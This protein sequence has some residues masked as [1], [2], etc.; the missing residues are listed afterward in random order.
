MG[1]IGPSELE[2][3]ISDDYAPEF[4]GDVNPTL[5][6][7]SS[8]ADVERTLASLAPPP[9]PYISSVSRPSLTTTYM[10][11]QTS[12]FMQPQPTSGHS[13]RDSVVTIANRGLDFLTQFYAS[14]N[15]AFAAS[16]G[17]G[18][19]PGYGA[20]TYGVVNAGAQGAGGA[21]GAGA[22]SLVDGIVNWVRQNTMLTALI[23]GGLF[24]YTRDPK[25]R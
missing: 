7:P 21:V 24:L 3:I 12:T 16:S 19:A 1:A 17:I 25:R 4:M 22:G 2:L 6:T 20:E 18:Y 15:P 10:P 9:N 8:Y 23:V 11:P 13:T 14:K 5:P